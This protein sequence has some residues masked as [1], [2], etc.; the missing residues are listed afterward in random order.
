MGVL[1]KFYKWQYSG[2]ITVP[3]VCGLILL[4][5][6]SYTGTLEFYDSFSCSGLMAYKINGVSLDGNP[7]YQEMSEESK[8]H[9]DEILEECKID[10]YWYKD[11]VRV[12][13]SDQAILE[14]KALPNLP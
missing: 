7:T 5:W 8:I 12:G 6:F 3:L 2:L 14:N 13:M 10:G 11:K 9:Y 1:R 4:A